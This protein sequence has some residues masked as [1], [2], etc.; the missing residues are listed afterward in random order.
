MG[1]AVE[2]RMD[3]MGLAVETR[4]DAMGLAVE[5]RMDA[6]KLAIETRLDAIKLAIETR[7]DQMRDQTKARMDQMRDQT[8]SRMDQMRDQ[9]RARMDQMRDQTKARMD[10][11]RDQ[12]KAR[13]DQM[14]DQTKARMDQIRDQTRDRMDQI[15]AAARAAMLAIQNI[16]STQLAGILQGIQNAINNINPVINV[17]VQAPPP[18]IA[19]PRNGDDDAADGRAYGG[20]VRRGVGY[21]VG[22]KGPEYFI[23]R[24]HGTIL[25]HAQ[26]VA[27][28][29]AG[30]TG[31]VTINVNLDGKL[32]AK[33]VKK[34][35]PRRV[36][37]D[38]QS[39]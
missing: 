33:V 17:Y 7:M 16:V 6:I 12:T 25:P 11:M 18:R 9:T 19:T 37:I 30:G 1:L 24:S 39:R 3:A 28:G 10:Q 31:P 13:M 2:T 26:P 23:P 20:P 4:M 21:V 32:I 8:R 15:V 38:G 35:L 27:A 29:P 14:R 5:T 22:E 36:D 34:H